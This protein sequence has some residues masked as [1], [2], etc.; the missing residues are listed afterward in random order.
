MVHHSF[1]QKRKKNVIFYHFSYYICSPAGLRFKPNPENMK[2]IKVL[3]G[4]ILFSI[5]LPVRGQ[6]QAVQ[7]TLQDRDRII[8][9]EQ[10]LESVNTQLSIKIE[11]VRTEMGIKFDAIEKR[12]DQRFDQLFNFLWVIIGVFITITA[13]VIGFAFWDRR[14]ALSPIKKENEKVISSLREFARHQ[15]KLQEILRNAGLL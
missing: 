11:G 3:I 7:F 10:K 4:L 9:T 8:R 1:Q 12:F 15:P 14:I 5:L 6:N 2:T 13:S